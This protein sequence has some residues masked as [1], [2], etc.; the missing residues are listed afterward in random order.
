MK[1]QDPAVW[2]WDEIGPEGLRF[3]GKMSASISHEVKNVLAIINENAGLLNDLVM[4][5]ERGVAV[6]PQRLVGIAGTID[7]QVR[8]AD[9]IAKNLNRFAHSADHLQGEVDLAEWVELALALVGRFAS[10]RG[11]RLEFSPPPATPPVQSA[12]FFLLN[13][14]WLGL[15]MAMEL[16][17]PDKTVLLQIE[18]AAGRLGLVYDRLKPLSDND[19]DFV[20]DGHVRSLALLLGA[21]PWQDVKSGRFGF[22][23]PCE[24]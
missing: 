17:G 14:I 20:T 11:I 1:A 7:K 3:Y 9:L 21:N 22:D 6:E 18:V 13:L 15:D 5:A 12:P 23:L 8:R 4:M 24:R 10:N 2:A 16:A 19:W